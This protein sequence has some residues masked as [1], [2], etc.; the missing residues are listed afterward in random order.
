MPRTL[1]LYATRKGM[2]FKTAGIIGDVLREKFNHDVNVY[3]IKEKK[4]INIGEYDN[5]VFGSSIVMGK[6]KG[7]LRRYIKK[8][9]LTGKKTAVFVSAAGALSQFPDD[10][11]KGT[12]VGVQSYIDPVIEELNIKPDAKTAFGGYFKM[13][14]KVLADNWNRDDI[15]KWAQELGEI[16]K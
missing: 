1:V 15:E 4:R 3:S 5:I 13:F 8:Q 10:I 7:N 2:S 6:W 9:D 14:G 16:F 11:E 12:K